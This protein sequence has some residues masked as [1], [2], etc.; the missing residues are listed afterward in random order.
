MI[1]ITAFVF[2]ILSYRLLSVNMMPEV[3]YPSLTV[4]TNYLGAAPEEVETIVTKPLEQALGVVRSLVEM[5]S[6][7][8]TEYSDILLEF[9]WDVN[10]S[11][12]TQDVREK[13]DLVFLPEDVKQPLILRY[14]PSLD[15]LIRIGLNSDS[16]DL[17]E[18]RKLSEDILKQEL[19]KLPGVAAVKVKGGEEDEIRISIDASRLAQLNISIEEVIQKLQAEIINL[20]GGKL[21]EGETE[22]I[23]RTLNEFQHIEEIGE[24]VIRSQENRFVRLQDIADVTKTSKRK[25]SQTRV[26]QQE[27]VEL[28]I[29]KESDANPISVSKVVKARIFG[30]KKNQDKSERKKSPSEDRGGSKSLQEILTERVQIHVLSDQAE[31]IQLAV[32]EVKSAAIYG[33][34]LAMIVLLLFLGRLKDTIIVGIV[35][36]VS[37]VCTFAAMHIAKVSVNIMSLGGLA[38]GIGMMVDNAIVVI[39][40]I[41]QR[42][43]KGDDP[44]TAAVLGTKSVGGAVTASTLTTIVVFFPIIFVTGVAGQVF[45]DMALTVIISL[46]VSLLVALFFLP[47]LTVIGSKISAPSNAARW[48][49]TSNKLSSPWKTFLRTLNALKKR[50]ILI[51]ILSFPIVLNFVLVRLIL[52]YFWFAIYYLIFGLLFIIRLVSFKYANP[53]IRAISA[54]GGKGIGYFRSLISL[55]REMYVVLLKITLTNKWVVVFL[56]AVLTFAAYGYI[57]PRIGK[58]LMPNLSQ[59][60]FDVELHLP[61]GTSLDRTA[62]LIEPLEELISKSMEVKKISSRIGSEIGDTRSD[63]GSNFASLTVVLKTGGNLEEKEAAIV[64]EIRAF[65]DD[66]PSLKAI[67]SHPSLFTFKNPIELI[68]KNDDLDELRHISSKVEDRIRLLPYF[69]DVTSS[70]RPGH[71]EVII[72]F[73]RDKLARIGLNSRRAGERVR[74]AILGNVVTRFR[75]EDRRVD[76]RL[77]WEASNRESIIQL[78]NLILNPD[79]A[80]PVTL[81]EAAEIT[82]VEGP[83]EINHFAA[84]RSA[85][86]TSAI[87]NIS[88][89]AADDSVH[90]ILNDLNLVEGYDYIISGQRREMKDSLKSLQMALLLAVFL[91]YVVMAS[92]FE[93]FKSP[94]LILLTIPIAIAGILPVIYFLDLPLSIMTFIGMIVLTGIVVNDSIVLLDY[95]NQLIQKGENSLTAILKAGRAR[96]RPI[97][98]TSLTTILALLP[99]ALGVGEGVEIRRPMAITVILGLIF[100]TIVSLLVIPALFRVIYREK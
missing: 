12:A 62:K 60:V 69:K 67:I 96:F 33:G 79:Q 11:Q 84:I 17:T 89:S 8:R 56:I 86:I 73:N 61:I 7:S 82:I 22:Y 39:E 98:M 45:G 53:I 35:I 16:L 19:T 14:D 51:R 38:L 40:S 47:M 3:S 92:Q 31:F 63:E 68:L 1:V 44:I 71:P 65:C 57:F 81:E 64:E 49:R 91:V 24:I 78:R 5:S 21:I 77:Q 25:I 13:L 52:N 29:F 76:I 99:M 90:T 72:Q 2:G 42:L 87:E 94:F 41:Y 58:E 23:I 32:D 18:L 85:V 15:P 75:E 9:E 26:S 20:A 66:V 55:T 83:A 59:G 88:L 74:T 6:S 30:W 4:R 10:M 97:L 100:A 50:N 48:R 36:P 34:I 46:F 27:S 28:E 54:K 93:S 95:A 70:I 43:E 80:I 37:L